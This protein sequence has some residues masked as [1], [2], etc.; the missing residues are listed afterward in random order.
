MKKLNLFQ[1]L[2]INCSDAIDGKVDARTLLCYPF[3]I[4]AAGHVMNLGPFCHHSLPCGRHDVCHAGL[5]KDVNLL[6]L[7]VEKCIETCV[8]KEINEQ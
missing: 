8:C 4:C 6:N 5:V 2:C 3:S 7:Q 1:H